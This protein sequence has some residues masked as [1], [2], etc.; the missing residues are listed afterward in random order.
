MSSQFQ[1]EL[2][3]NQLAARKFLGTARVDLSSL[4]FIQGREIVPQIVH[5]LVGVFRATGCRRFDI[6]NHVPVLISPSEL[7]TALDASSLN[8]KDLSKRSQDGSLPFLK[9]GDNKLFSGIH[10]R[11]RIRA[12]T[13]FLDPND[14]WW[15]ISLYLVDN[16]GKNRQRQRKR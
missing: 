5:E 14:R 2:G 9:P 6:E 16:T 3:S 7:S 11:H 10:G 15:V 8:R 12:A 13:R 4:R 1:K